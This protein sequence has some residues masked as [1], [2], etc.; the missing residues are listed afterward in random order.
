[1]KR[2]KIRTLKLANIKKADYHMMLFFMILLTFGFAMGL[3]LS[4]YIDIADKDSLT[5]YMSVLIDKANP[6]DFFLS[7]FMI[8]TISILLI[9]LL[10]TSLC[11]FPL[12]SFLIYTKGVQIG[13]SC[14]LF[15]LSY[16]YKG[17]LGIIM[18]F[19]PQTIL[20]VIAFY[21]TTH[22]CLYFSMNLI[23]ASITT[24][25]IP[26]K[27]KCNKLLNLLFVSFIFIFISSYFKSTL[28]IEL[29]RV[30]ENL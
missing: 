11:G 29:I 4:K 23:N 1:M 19:L 30:F 21:V 20:D 3:F 10:G 25:T 24:A 13:F 5:T 14:A 22:F 18:V 6:N 27:N 9:V 26:L 12:I 17:I 7:Q 28:G 16:S 8:G 15:I 2:K